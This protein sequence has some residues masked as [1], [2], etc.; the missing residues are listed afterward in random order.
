M[1]GDAFILF[2][3][4]PEHGAVKTRLARA[5]GDDL[6]YEFYLRFLTDIASMAYEVNAEKVMV[7]DG[8]DAAVF[9]D[10]PSWRVIRQRGKDIGERMYNASLDVFELGFE[11]A[12]LIGSDCPDLPARMINQAFTKLAAADVVLGPGT[13]GGYY[14]FGCNRD[15]LCKSMFSGIP[16]STNAVFTETLKC[17]AQAGFV[18]ARLEP[19]SD[20]DEIDDLK[21]YY[22]RNRNRALMSQTMKYLDGTGIFNAQKY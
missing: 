19:W 21:Q 20:I 12:V 7:H 9:S 16:W 5:L 8:P 18:C 22:M 17:V 1:K 10:F 2:F 14:L 4:Y 15:C 6:A 11:R 13:D 3:K